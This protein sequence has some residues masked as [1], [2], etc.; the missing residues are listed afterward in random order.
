MTVQENKA[1]VRRFIEEVQNKQNL[2]L[3][4]E[5]FSPDC[6]DHSGMAQEGGIEGIKR[7]FTMINAA[8]PD[9]HFTVQDQVAEGDMVVTRKTLR[10]THTGE[11]FGIPATGKRIEMNVIDI[12]RVV[13]GKMTDHWAVADQLGMSQQLGVVPPPQPPGQ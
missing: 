1:V 5:L 9:A 7:F 8:F 10:A 2:D 4:D 6:V 11:L 12:L 13:D 3:V